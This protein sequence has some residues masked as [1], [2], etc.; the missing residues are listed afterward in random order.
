VQA[1]LP[2]GTEEEGVSI[3]STYTHVVMVMPPLIVATLASFFITTTPLPVYRTNWINYTFSFFR[4][5]KL[6]D[7]EEGNR[8]AKENQFLKGAGQLNFNWI[9]ILFIV[10]P[11]GV[12]NLVGWSY[13]ALTTRDYDTQ[14]QRWW[15]MALIV[16]VIVIV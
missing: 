12:V 5:F 8:I 7:A 15:Y 10:I 6:A 13:E 3:W 1:F 16:S 9:A 2:S 11:C 4:K 14:A